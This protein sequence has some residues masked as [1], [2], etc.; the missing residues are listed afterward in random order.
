MLVRMETLRRATIY[1][2]QNPQVAKDLLTRLHAR[3]ADSDAGSLGALAWFD[4]GYLAESYKQWMRAG[5]PDPAN[6]LDGYG[7]IEKAIGLRG[8]D[9]EMEFAA[10]LI[11]RTSSERDHSDHLG[12][13]DGGREGRSATC[14]ES[15]LKS[16]SL[17]DPGDSDP[18]HRGRVE[19]MQSR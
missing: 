13:S 11:T 8:S 4:L 6:G 7:W 15:R 9:P 5:E 18:R 19:K 14:S 1:A 3:A 16:Q 12:K 17:D 10:A 2:R